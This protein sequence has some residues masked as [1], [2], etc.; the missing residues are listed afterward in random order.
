MDVQTSFNEKINLSPIFLL[1][2]MALLG[3]V[4]DCTVKIQDKFNSGFKINLNKFKT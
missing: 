4:L 1:F 3:F 2:L